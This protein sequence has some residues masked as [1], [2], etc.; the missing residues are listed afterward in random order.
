VFGVKSSPAAAGGMVLGDGTSV[1]EGRRE[2]KRL[3][4]QIREQGQKQYEFIEKQIREHG[5]QWLKEEEEEMKKLQDA[6]M[7]DMKKGAFSW[8]PG[9][10]KKE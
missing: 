5:A 2:G 10:G 8:F 9:G 4:D 3:S 7:K 1:S 6:Q